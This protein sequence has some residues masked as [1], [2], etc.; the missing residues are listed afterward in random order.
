MKK[1]IIYYT[2]LIISTIIAVYIFT[3]P[4]DQIQKPLAKHTAR[5]ITN[6]KVSPERLF[7]IAWRNIK[8]QYVDPT[9]NGQNWVRWKNRYINKIE[10]IEDAHVAINSM[11]QSLDDPYS[12]FMNMP[13]YTQQNRTIN[14]NISGI[15]INVMSLA[16]KIVISNVIEDSPAQK[17]GVKIGDIILKVDDFEINNVKLEEAVK[18]IRGQKNTYVKLTLLRKNHVLVKNIKR[19]VVKLKTVK[20]QLLKHKIA[21]IQIASFMGSSVSDEFKTALSQSMEDNAKGVIIDLRGDA[22]GLLTNAVNM[23]NMII[24][25][26]TILSIV[27]RNGVKADL[28]TDKQAFFTEK[29]IVILINKGTASSAEI[30]TGALRDN[31]KAI[32]VGETTYG[33]NSVQQIIPLPNHTGMN[34]TVAKYLMPNDEDIHN[35]GIAPDYKISYT[36][37]DYKQNTDPQ[38]IKAQEILRKN[39]IQK[40][41]K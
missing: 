41:K 9:M 35:K 32:L 7:L 11:L 28:T 21:Y 31:H 6:Q 27:Y 36:K 22:G 23:A 38:L 16:N 5:F 24:N 29:P 34:L 2:V 26:G 12:K 37:K 17:E 4:I 30:L 40:N 1:R 39:I 3:T 8:N 13:E 10:T 15:G 14:S 18:H 19:D 25:D 33:K 20:Y